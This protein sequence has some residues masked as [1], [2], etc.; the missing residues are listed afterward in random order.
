[1][2]DTVKKMKRQTTD[3]E[4]IYQEIFLLKGSFPKYTKNS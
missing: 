1:M 4:K 2:K 3:C